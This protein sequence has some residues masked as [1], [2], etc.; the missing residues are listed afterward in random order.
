MR[1][2]AGINNNTRHKDAEDCDERSPFTNGFDNVNHVTR[3]Q[4]GLQL[5]GLTHR[6]DDNTYA[7]AKLFAS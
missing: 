4:A 3:G 2:Y 5:A 6:L 1:D 7:Q